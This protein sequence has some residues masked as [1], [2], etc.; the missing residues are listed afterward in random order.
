MAKFKRNAINRT[1]LRERV[2]ARAKEAFMAL[3]YGWIAI[4]LSV[5]HSFANTNG[6]ARQKMVGGP[7]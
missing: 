5:R 1:L 4:T 6:G 2:A 3:S 7:D